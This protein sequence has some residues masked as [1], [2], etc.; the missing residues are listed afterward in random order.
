[1]FK[2]NEICSSFCQSISIDWMCRVWFYNEILN[3]CAHE[4]G[5]K[6]WETTLRID[7]DRVGCQPICLVT[8]K[9][10]NKLKK[11][12]KTTNKNKSIE[13]YSSV[14]VVVK[15]IERFALILFSLRLNCLKKFQRQSTVQQKRTHDFKIEL[16]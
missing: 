1:M 16:Q 11:W 14:F 15:N 13:G 2:G 3:Q 4:L 12:T 5:R 7:F 6:A 10:S 9:G 8:F